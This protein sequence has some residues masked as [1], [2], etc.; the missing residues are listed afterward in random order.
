MGLAQIRLGLVGA[1]ERAVIGQAHGGV[2]LGLDLVRPAG[3]PSSAALDV[4]IASA[5]PT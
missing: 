5:Y 4:E 1:I 3:I 2:D